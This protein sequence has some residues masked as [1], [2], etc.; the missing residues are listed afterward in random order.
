[1][2]KY[3]LYLEIYMNYATFDEGGQGCAST[4]CSPVDKNIPTLSLRRVCRGGEINDKMRGDLE[5]RLPFFGDVLIESPGTALGATIFTAALADCG[6]V[7]K[8]M[9]GRGVKRKS[10]RGVQLSNALQE[11][12]KQ[13]PTPPILS[14]TSFAQIH[15]VSPQGCRSF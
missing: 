8:A 2:N 1:V 5:S 14:L 11:R 10:E 15:H 6:L 4:M 13:T 7:K 12:G 9:V 3:S